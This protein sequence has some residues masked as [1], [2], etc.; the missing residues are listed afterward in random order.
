MQKLTESHVLAR[1]I[2]ELRPRLSEA[3][4]HARDREGHVI[5]PV[6]TTNSIATFHA[7]A[8]PTKPARQ[9]SIG[10]KV[11]IGLKPNRFTRP[12]YMQE[13]SRICN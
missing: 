12:M 4:K 6:E 8:D 7:A 2:N 11:K 3:S 5:R 1:L 10:R 9:S 13:V